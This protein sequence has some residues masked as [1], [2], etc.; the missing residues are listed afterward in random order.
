MLTTILLVFSFVLFAL[1]AVWHLWGAPPEPHRF[2]L[3]SAG[4]ALWVLSIILATNHL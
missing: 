3:V 4:L 2:S 1:A